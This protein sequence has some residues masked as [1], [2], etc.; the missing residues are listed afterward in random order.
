MK[1]ENTQNT[2]QPPQDWWL[3]VPLSPQTVTCQTEGSL[4]LSMSDAVD[5]G[6]CAV[7]LTSIV[8][9]KYACEWPV[10]VPC[11]TVPNG[12]VA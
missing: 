11:W 1:E 4:D 3:E 7:G 5:S 9:I 8:N 6:H 2:A 10:A 12:V